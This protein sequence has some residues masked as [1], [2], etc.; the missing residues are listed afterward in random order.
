[1]LFARNFGVSSPHDTCGWHSCAE[2]LLKLGCARECV[3]VCVPP[4]ERARAFYSRSSVPRVCRQSKLLRSLGRL[5]SPLSPFSHTHT[6]ARAHRF[7]VTSLFYVALASTPFRLR[8]FFSCARTKVGC[9]P[10]ARTRSGEKRGG[11]RERGRQ[12]AREEKKGWQDPRGS[13]G[14]HRPPQK[15]AHTATSHPSPSFLLVLPPPP[16][17]PPPPPLPHP[18]RLTLSGL[19]VCAPW[20]KWRGGGTTLYK[21]LPWNVKQFASY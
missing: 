11:G 5:S 4:R 20:T 8:G 7:C 16:P 6:R 3:R 17:P 13:I 9:R 19:L 12:R 18:L 21:Y 1:M 14:G 2:C 10:G 15:S